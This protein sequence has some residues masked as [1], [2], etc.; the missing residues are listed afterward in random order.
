MQ[1]ERILVAGGTD[2]SS[3]GAL[4]L[5]RYRPNGALDRTFSGDGKVTIPD[6]QYR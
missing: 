2:N 5:M 3:T 6:R 4:L 1:G